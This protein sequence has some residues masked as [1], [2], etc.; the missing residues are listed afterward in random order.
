ML[1]LGRPN[2]YLQLDQIHRYTFHIEIDGKHKKF[3]ETAS[4]QSNAKQID[5][6]NPIPFVEHPKNALALERKTLC[7]QGQTLDQ[8][9][10]P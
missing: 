3:L 10:A 7:P 8:N 4:G 1:C 9:G 5:D 2:T 6:F